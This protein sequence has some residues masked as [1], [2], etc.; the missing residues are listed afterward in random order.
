MTS[1][2]HETST[3]APIETVFDWH[4]RRGAFHRLTPPWE[5]V[6]EKRADPEIPEVGSER[7]MKFV[8]GP[9]KMTWHAKHTK[10]VNKTYGVTLGKCLKMKLQLKIL[11]EAQNRF[12]SKSFSET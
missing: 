12:S 5:L 2:T 10:Y 6:L 11:G 7:V 8:M 3:E 4:K 9:A 1:Y